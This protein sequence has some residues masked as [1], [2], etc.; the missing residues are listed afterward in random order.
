M[1]API[2]APVTAL[3][4]ANVSPHTNAAANE[5]PESAVAIT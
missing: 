5:P 2:T 3:F 1:T 4:A